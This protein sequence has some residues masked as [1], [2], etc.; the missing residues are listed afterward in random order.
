MDTGFYEQLLHPKN[1]RESDPETHWDAR[2]EGFHA[3]GRLKLR[4]ELPGKLISYLQS[5]QFL[6]STGSVLDIGC[7]SGRYA[8]AMARNARH[9]TAA[10]IS[11]NMLSYLQQ[12]AH[13]A[14]LQNIETIKSD[15]SQSDISALGWEKRFDLVMAVMCPA[16]KS[17]PALKKMSRAA[18]GHCLIGQF[19]TAHDTLTDLIYRQLN[20]TV[21]ADPHNDRNAVYAL[22][23]LL[24]LDGLEPEITY[25]RENSET[26]LT[27]EQA[28]SHCTRRLSDET[29]LHRKIEHILADQLEDGLIKTSGS[30]TLALILWKAK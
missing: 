19:I 17:A 15:W 16:V 7:G 29:E 1:V 27:L 23:N 14:G 3:A 25:L 21:P 20:L 18:K 22:F 8:L 26:S 28:L 12:D 11:G 5:R 6:T 30:S 9:V 4:A 10:D 24:W 2:A 13:S